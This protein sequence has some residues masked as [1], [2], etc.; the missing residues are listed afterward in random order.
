M[1]RDGAAR[2]PLQVD[3]ERAVTPDRSVSRQMAPWLVAHPELFKGPRVPDPVDRYPSQWTG[4]IPGE[5]QGGVTT[6][7]SGVWGYRSRRLPDLS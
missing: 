5:R 6:A 7:V 3:R 1:T 4:G 2:T